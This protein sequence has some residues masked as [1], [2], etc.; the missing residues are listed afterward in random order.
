MTNFELR[1]TVCW[2]DGHDEKIKK[3]LK[4]SSMVNL[5]IISNR[6]VIDMV[7]FRGLIPVLYKTKKY[8]N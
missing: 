8:M 5:C 3:D 4:F 7:F 1:V 2:I 6:N